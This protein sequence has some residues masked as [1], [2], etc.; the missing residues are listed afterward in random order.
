MTLSEYN[1]DQL[2]S[3]TAIR[4]ACTNLSAEQQK[5]LT[6]SL[7]PY[8]EFRR[9]VD[10]FQKHYFG[11]FCKASCFQTGLSACCGFESIITF[12]A[13]QAVTYLISEEDERQQLFQLLAQPNTS[14]KCVFLGENGCTWRLPPVTCALYLCEPAKSSVFGDHPEARP[15][16][17]A[18]RER[19]K[20]F[21]HPSQPVL[22][23]G[24]ERAFLEVGA[25]SPHMFFHSSPGLLR[26][27]AKAGILDEAWCSSAKR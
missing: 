2:T 4:I 3:L 23:D 18:L 15:V 27:K 17:E 25:I 14:R 5:L 16:W 7:Q 12:F 26:L 21:T 1:R 19:E 24:L 6:E 22:F 10:E 8:L 20:R 11:D 13:D 9:E